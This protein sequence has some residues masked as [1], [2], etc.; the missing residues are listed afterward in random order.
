MFERLRL[1]VFLLVIALLFSALVHAENTDIAV[2]VIAKDAKFIGTSM[3]GARVLL[4]DVNTGVLLASGVTAGSTGD[5][6]RI[7]KEPHERG[8][9][10]STEGA[11]VFETTLDLAEPTLIRF[12]ASGPLGQPQGAGEVSATQWVVPGK[13]LSGGDGMLLV[14]P[15]FVVDVLSPPA[16]A[17]YSGVPHEVEIHANLVMTCGCPTAPGGLWDSDGFEIRAMIRQEGHKVGELPLSYLDETSQFG[18]TWIVE[19]AGVYEIIVYAYDAENGNTG[20]DRTT[21]IVTED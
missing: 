3:G 2:R 16:H 15:G 7:M 18:T 13:H 9:A 21:I 6:A 8:Q 12:T 14:M 5:T 1:S 4:H 20:L 10:L 17:R 11:A 19:E